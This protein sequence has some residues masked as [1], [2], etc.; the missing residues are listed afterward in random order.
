VV[1]KVRLKQLAF[2]EA[3]K[4][5]VCLTKCNKPLEMQ[6]LDVSF[7]QHIAKELLSGTSTLSICQPAS[8]SLPLKPTVVQHRSTAT[9]I[10]DSS[11]WIGDDVGPI[12]FGHFRIVDNLP[13]SLPLSELKLAPHGEFDAK[14]FYH[15]LHMSP[16]NLYRGTT[17][18]KSHVIVPRIV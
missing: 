10:E 3:R 2:C 17:S 12:L 11:L 14:F 13:Y 15:A 8:K 5:L 1:I 6:T 4:N 18:A 9:N 16:M 7:S